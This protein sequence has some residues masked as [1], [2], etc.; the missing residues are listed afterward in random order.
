M[1]IRTLV[2]VSPCTYEFA[3][4]GMGVDVCLCGLVN[5]VLECIYGQQTSV[6]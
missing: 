5:S 1:Y 4:M 2:H 6:V 3:D